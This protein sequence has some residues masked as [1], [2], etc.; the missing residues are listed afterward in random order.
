MTEE[1]QQA[2]MLDLGQTTLC[3]APRREIS[4][5]A[6]KEMQWWLDEYER[7]AGRTRH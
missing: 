2:C 3:A 7:R 4:E 5:E 6:I 1:E